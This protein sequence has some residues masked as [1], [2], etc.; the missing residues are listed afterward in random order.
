MGRRIRFLPGIDRSAVSAKPVGLQ[1][2]GGHHFDRCLFIVYLFHR[3]TGRLKAIAK[4][5]APLTSGNRSGRHDR[6]RSDMTGPLR[7]P[8]GPPWAREAAI[9]RPKSALGRGERDR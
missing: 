8:F 5:M 9:L 1:P 2:H 3:T 7:D 4:T 6:I